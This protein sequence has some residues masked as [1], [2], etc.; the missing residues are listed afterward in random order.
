[1]K[2]AGY[3]LSLIAVCV[4][5][6]CAARPIK[7]A[8]PR[9]YFVGCSGQVDEVDSRTGKLLR[10]RNLAGALAIERQQTVD[11][12]TFDGCLMN[13]AVYVPAQAAFYSVVPVQFSDKENGTKDYRAVRVSLTDLT[14]RMAF[15]AGR[16]Y[17]VESLQPVD[18]FPHTP[19][20]ETVAVLRRL[21]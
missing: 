2:S 6:A 15:A 1:M 18:M 16:G 21:L 9:L 20:V 19:H 12:A 4:T 7:P 17:R 8:A 14:P 3:L 13:Q 11:G 5:Q 10:S